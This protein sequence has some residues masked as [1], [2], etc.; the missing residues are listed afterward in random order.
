MIY[1]PMSFGISLYFA[2]SGVCL[3]ATPATQGVIEFRGSIVEPSCMSRFSE[4]TGFELTDCPSPGRAPAINARRI[5]PVASISTTAR[6]AVNVR[7]LADSGQRSRYQ[8]YQLADDAG[9]PVRSGMYLV[10]L[11]MP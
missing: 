3:A 9:S 2:L 6:P 7:Q 4:N 10:T 1:K 5:E 11:T 8:H